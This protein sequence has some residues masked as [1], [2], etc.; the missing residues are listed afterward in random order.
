MVRNPCKSF[1]YPVELTV[2]VMIGYR[3]H[4]QCRSSKYI[5][6]LNSGGTRQSTGEKSNIDINSIPLNESLFVNS[7]WSVVVQFGTGLGYS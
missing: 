2:C 5:L 6:R 3:L 7:Y 1:P 4:I